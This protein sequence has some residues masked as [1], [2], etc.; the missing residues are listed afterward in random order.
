MIV[1]TEAQPEEDPLT[2]WQRTDAD[3]ERGNLLKTLSSVE[4]GK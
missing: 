1:R 3:P 2:I 4:D